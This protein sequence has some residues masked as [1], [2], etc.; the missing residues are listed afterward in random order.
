MRGEY[1]ILLLVG[2]FSF[3]EDIVS[4]ARA[5]SCFSSWE[6]LSEGDLEEGGEG[7]EEKT[8]LWSLE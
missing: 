6:E 8:L 4:P 2:D 5:G 7:G 1:Y 3:V